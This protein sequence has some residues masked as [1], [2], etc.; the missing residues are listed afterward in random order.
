LGS[1]KE[2]HAVYPINTAGLTDFGPMESEILTWGKWSILQCISLEMSSLKPCL[3]YF[4]LH[5]WF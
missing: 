4:P 1:G 3:S 2:S 5:W